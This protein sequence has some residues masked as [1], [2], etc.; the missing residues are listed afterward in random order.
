M[1]EQQEHHEEKR[2]VSG[3]I[4]MSII[5]AVI[6]LAGLA[7]L[8]MTDLVSMATFTT[9]LKTILIVIGIGT[10]AS[11]TVSLLSRPSSK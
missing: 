11:V 2:G 4:K 8:L 10:L 1:S 5:I 6:L 7:I 9:Y 3:I